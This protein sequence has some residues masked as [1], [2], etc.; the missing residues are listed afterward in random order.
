MK[1]FLAFVLVLALAFAPAQAKFGVTNL[2]GFGGKQAAGGD[3]NTVL[4]LH[5]DGADTSTTFT[6]SSTGG[7][8]S[9]HTATAVGNAQ[10]ETAAPKFGT[11]SGL[12]DGDTDRVDVSD[13]TDFDFGTGQYTID[14]WVKTSASKNHFPYYNVD[15]SNNGIRIEIRTDGTIRFREIV[16]GTLNTV[17]STGTVNSGSW[18]HVAVSRGATGGTRLFI[19]GTEE[20]QMASAHNVN[21]TATIN[22]GGRSGTASESL[23]GELDEFRVS[24]I[25]RWTSGFTP[26]TAP[27]D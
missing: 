17:Q 1:R 14:F 9:P 11:A 5:M 27:S 12:F 8:G 3:P 7:S 20:G 21:S 26:P 13:H 23:D 10:L 6:D 18:V 24:N 16:G 22:I 4:L 2:I 25:G 15:G 19:G